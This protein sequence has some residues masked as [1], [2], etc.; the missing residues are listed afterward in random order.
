MCFKKNKFKKTNFKLNSFFKDKFNTNG[1]KINDFYIKPNI[2][3]KVSYNQNNSNLKVFT[4]FNRVYKIKV[5]SISF[6]IDRPVSIK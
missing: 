6:N 1:I 5:N 4:K 2:I 3:K